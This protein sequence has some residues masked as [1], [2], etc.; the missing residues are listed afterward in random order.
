MRFSVHRTLRLKKIDP[1]LPDEEERIQ[2]EGAD[3]FEEAV[4]T[5]DQKVRERMSVWKQSAE[6][7]KVTANEVQTPAQENPP[8][9]QVSVEA[10]QPE[11]AA[12]T[13][14][15]PAPEVPQTTEAPVQAPAPE[16][17]AAP[18][19]VSPAQVTAHAPEAPVPTAQPS[20]AQPQ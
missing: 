2:V 10:P 18:E 20:A 12:E 8:Q 4:Q 11:V 13:P 16:T 14:V 3:S 9:G 17:T 1:V 7:F 6:S 19:P 15:A 5:L